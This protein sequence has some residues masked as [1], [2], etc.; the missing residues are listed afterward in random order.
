MLFGGWEKY[1]NFDRILSS[2]A[3]VR[4]MELKFENKGKDNQRALT[5]TAGVNYLLLS[6][7]L[8][9]LKQY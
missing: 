1:R 6:H 7:T 2:L 8:A 9:V 5:N 3:A 4:K